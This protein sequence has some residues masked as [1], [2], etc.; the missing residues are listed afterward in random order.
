[1]SFREVTDTDCSRVVDGIL[2]MSKAQTLEETTMALV[3]TAMDLVP[4]DHGGYAEIDEHFQPHPAL[5]Q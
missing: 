5:L 1:M 3:H 4:C 2:A